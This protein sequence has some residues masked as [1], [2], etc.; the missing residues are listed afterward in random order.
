MLIKGETLIDRKLAGMLFFIYT[1]ISAEAEHAQYS[2]PIFI[3]I[4]NYCSQREG[5]ITIDEVFYFG[6]NKIEVVFTSGKLM[7]SVS[8][9]ADLTYDFLVAEFEGEALVKSKTK[10]FDNIENLFKEIQMDLEW[11]LHF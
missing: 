7:L 11:V 2:N 3:F 4:K 6:D 5:L 8:I 1:S 9:L 10:N